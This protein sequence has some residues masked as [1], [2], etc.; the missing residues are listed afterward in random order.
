VCGSKQLKPTLVP[1]GRD[2]L[3]CESCKAEW[4]LIIGLGGLKWAELERESENGEGKALIGKRYEKGQWQKLAE[5]IMSTK[6]AVPI[7]REVNRIIREKEIIKEKEVIVKIR[8]PYCKNPYD[9][10]LDKCP[11]CG[12]RAYPQRRWKPITFI[13]E[14]MV[15]ILLDGLE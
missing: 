1:G 5:K 9:E 8:R 7:T 11:Y 3:L 14:P 4:H 13:F 2:S 12:A 10:T 6:I 15:L